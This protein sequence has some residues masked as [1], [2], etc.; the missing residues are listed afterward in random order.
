MVHHDL[1]NF[2]LLGSL[3]LLVLSLR[4]RVV[5]G[6]SRSLVEEGGPSSRLCELV[7]IAFILV[8]FIQSFT[9]FSVFCRG[10]LGV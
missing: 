9:Y 10:I 6:L 8:V 5:G 7:K 2:L 3:V 1:C 4:I